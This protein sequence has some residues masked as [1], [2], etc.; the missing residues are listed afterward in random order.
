[1]NNPKFWQRQHN[2]VIGEIKYWLNK[3]QK[4][5]EEAKKDSCTETKKS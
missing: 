5:I 3:I 1:M 2:L 4:S